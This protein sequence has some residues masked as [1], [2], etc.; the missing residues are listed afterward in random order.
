MT[1]RAA[2]SAAAGR[3]QAT[4]AASS[5]LIDELCLRLADMAGRGVLLAQG[6]LSP[7]KTSWLLDE[8]SH[9]LGQADRLIERWR[10]E[11]AGRAARA[12]RPDSPASRADGAAE[13]A[14]PR[15]G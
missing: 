15:G 5:A 12:P 6:A 4:E 14:E 13:P 8:I 1:E 3:G 11:H 7:R 10:A 9:D 2:G